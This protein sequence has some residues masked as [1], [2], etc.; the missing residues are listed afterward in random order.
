MRKKRVRWGCKG[1]FWG[2]GRLA[3]RPRGFRTR[4][5]LRAKWRGLA[6]LTEG[7]GTL[8]SFWRTSS[9]S[10]K[11]PLTLLC[12]DKAGGS[13]PRC[14][15]NK[16]RVVAKWEKRTA[17]AP[18]GVQRRRRKGCSSISRFGN[19]LYTEVGIRWLEP[20]F[21]SGLGPPRVG[22]PSQAKRRSK[23]RSCAQKR[24]GSS[25]WVPLWPFVLGRE[26]AGR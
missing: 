3:L 14:H 10:N 12:Q 13:N 11:A 18:M 19:Q 9:C 6:D 17:L 1:E 23:T 21:R 8:D 2:L 16:F 26:R 24:G 25:K 20:I 22:S 5:E 4:G 7:P 15:P